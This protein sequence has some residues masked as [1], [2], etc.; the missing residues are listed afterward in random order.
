MPIRMT[1]WPS[2]FIL[3]RYSCQF[4]CSPRAVDLHVFRAAE[5]FAHDQERHPRVAA[6][7]P[8]LEC[9]RARVKN[10]PALGVDH[11]SDERDLRPAVA[12]AGDQHA[13]VVIG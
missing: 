12:L 4:G 8:H 2:F 7:V 3:S 5:I 13:A 6:D 11:G 10:H 9:V 1:T